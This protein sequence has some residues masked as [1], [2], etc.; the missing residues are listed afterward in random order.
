MKILMFLFFLSLISCSKSKQAPQLNDKTPDTPETPAI[1]TPIRLSTEEE[2]L[3]AVLLQAE[4]P[5]SIADNIMKE[6]GKSPAFFDSL[7]SAITGDPFLHFLVDK[8]HPLPE[9]YEPEDLVPL[10]GGRAYNINR[11][12]LRLRKEAAE[13]LEQMS[14]SALSEGVSLLVSSTYRSYDY[15]V[16]V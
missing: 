13:S 4:I 7:A 11:N 15:Q 1:S 2:N 14:A 3:T 8:T 6:A 9:R 16:T 5:Q 10:K 12:D